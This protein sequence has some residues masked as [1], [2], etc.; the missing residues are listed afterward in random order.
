MIYL[1]REGCTKGVPINV[2][3]QLNT[4]DTH[5]YTVHNRTSNRWTTIRNTLMQLWRALEF[6]GQNLRSA[7][8]IPEHICLPTPIQLQSTDH[9]E[10]I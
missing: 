7:G 2:L 1:E 5:N 4:K 6:Q 8:S 10:I 3:P 9:V